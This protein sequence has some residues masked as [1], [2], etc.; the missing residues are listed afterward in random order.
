MKT[1]RLSRAVLTAGVLTMTSVAMALP[2]MV[3]DFGSTY[4]VKKDGTIG[5]ASCSVCHV[6]KTTKLNPYG[7]D[8]KS[9]MAS[10]KA[11]KLTAGVLKKVE[12]LDSD[13]DG[14]SNLEEIK[15]DKLPGDAKSK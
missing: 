4:G 13:K 8:L 7:A 3:K 9:A 11:S 10:E 14:K 15:G 12:G 6:G 5:K 1:R 2:S